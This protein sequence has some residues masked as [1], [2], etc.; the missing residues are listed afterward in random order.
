[1]AEIQRRYADHLY[2]KHDYDGAMAQYVA[3]IGQLEP[4]YVIKKF[5]DAQRIHNLTTYLEELHA[6]VK[7]GKRE[8]HLLGAALLHAGQI[9]H[10]CMSLIPRADCGCTRCTKET[11]IMRHACLGQH[12]D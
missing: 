7:Q 10:F 12:S 8:R 11:A 5:L 9:L 1:M 3:T 6:Q 4:S 2:N